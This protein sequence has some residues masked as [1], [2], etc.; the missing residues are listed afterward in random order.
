MDGV[1]HLLLPPLELHV[2]GRIGHAPEEGLAARDEV[3]QAAG[4]EEDEGCDAEEVEEEVGGGVGIVLV[5]LF[6]RGALFSG[7][8][9]LLLLL[10]VL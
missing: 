6:S 10:F 5:D 8:L 3:A 1:Y 2:F 7:L 4:G 9:C